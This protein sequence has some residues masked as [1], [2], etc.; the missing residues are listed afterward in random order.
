MLLISTS[1]TFVIQE[2]S[3][4]TR[5]WN[6][7]AALG[8]K[9]CKANQQHQ[10]TKVKQHVLAEEVPNNINRNQ[11][12]NHVQSVTS[13][14]YKHQLKRDWRRSS[15]I[16]VFFWNYIQPRSSTICCL[17]RHPNQDQSIYILK[18]CTY[19]FTFILQQPDLKPQTHGLFY[20]WGP[21]PPFQ[22]SSPFK[23]NSKIVVNFILK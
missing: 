5:T 21:R 16:S 15:L 11:L 1:A 10:H 23:V 18:N 8:P 13:P 7:K 3:V 6:L 14:Q 17:K 4:H 2:M 22:S 12:S 20:C 9:P 19:S